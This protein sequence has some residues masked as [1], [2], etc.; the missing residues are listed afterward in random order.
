M[1]RSELYA[2]DADDC[3]SARLE[4]RLN[5]TESVPLMAF[6]DVKNAKLCKIF[7]GEGTEMF[8]NGCQRHVRNWVKGFIMFRTCRSK[9]DA[10][11]KM[12]RTFS[13]N[14]FAHPNFG[15]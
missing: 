9:F 6:Y 14:F 12:F 8:S 10:F 13:D 3:T 7:E 15:P 11:F 1:L 2:Q 5:L 4:A